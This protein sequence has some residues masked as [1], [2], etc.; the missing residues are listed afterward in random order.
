MLTHP[1]RVTRIL[2]LAAVLAAVPACSSSSTEPVAGPPP[3]TVTISVAASDVSCTSTGCQLHAVL[4]STRTSQSA[5]ARVTEVQPLLRFVTAVSTG[6]AFV[7]RDTSQ[8]D[9]DGRGGVSFFV[10]R[11]Q[12]P[13]TLVLC[14]LGTQA[15]QLGRIPDGCAVLTVPAP[16]A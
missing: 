8:T 11:G 3:S 9:S 13:A 2:C 15:T 6:G 14:P 7:I 5:G 1:A 10:A 12:Q 16:R 4:R